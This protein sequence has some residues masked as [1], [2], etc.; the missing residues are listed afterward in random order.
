MTTPHQ[1]PASIPTLTLSLPRGERLRVERCL[2]EAEKDL[3]AVRSLCG[4]YGLPV[5]LGLVIATNTIK[6]ARNRLKE[7]QNP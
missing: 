7:G 3:L 2:R 6:E 5:S 1:S 4:S